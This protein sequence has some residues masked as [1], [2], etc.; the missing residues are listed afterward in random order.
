MPRNSL[1]R[2][3]TRLRQPTKDDFV[4]PVVYHGASTVIETAGGNVNGTEL[5]YECSRA[6]RK[7]R[8]QQVEEVK[9]RLC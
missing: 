4:C 1:S 3:S 9:M 5:E 7:I 8:A 2:R 6:L